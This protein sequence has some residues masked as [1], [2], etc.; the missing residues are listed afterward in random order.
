MATRI[1]TINFLPDIFRTPTNSQFLGATLD[2]IVDQPNTMKIEGYIGSK[3][4][5]GINAKD[6]YVVEPTKTRTDYQLEPGVVFTKKDTSTA[7]DFIS[8][9]GIVDALKLAGGVTNNNDRLFNSEFYS[10]DSFTNLDPLI[11]YTQYYWLKDGAPA[12]TIST[13]TVYNTSAYVVN[14]LPNGYEITSDTDPA[15]SINPTITLLR[16]GIYTFAV[17]QTSQFWIQGAPGVTGYDPSQPNMQTR[18]VLGVENNGAKVGLVTFTVPQK[19]AQD[20]YVNLPGNNLVDVVSDK[21]FNQING[22]LLSEVKNIDGLTSLEGK[23]V[24]FYND[25]VPNEQGYVSKFY[26]ITLYDEDGGNTYIPPGTVADNNNYEGGYYT[27]VSATFYQITYTDGPTPD[28]PML[29]LV[30]YSA[31]PTNEKIT[32]TSGTTYIGRNFYRNAQGTINIVPYLSAILDTLYYQD[33]ISPDQVGVI[34]LVEN[35]NFNVLDIKSILG[36]K[37]YTSPNKVVFTN[38]LKVSFKGNITPA[39]YSTNEYYVE[40]VGTAIKLIPVTELIAPESFTKGVTLPYDSVPYDIGNYDAQLYI[41]VDQDYI[42]IARDSIDKNPWSRSNRWFHI[43]VI[44]ATAKYNN[45][46]EIATKLATQAN[47]AKRPII[48]F[49]PNLRL[50]NTGVIGKAPVDF[51]DVRTTDAFNQVAGQ[52]NYYPDVEVFT[53][54]TAVIAKQIFPTTSTTI[55]IPIDHDTRSF[56]LLGSG[57]FAVGQYIKDSTNLLPNSAQISAISSDAVNMTITVQWEYPSI[58]SSD[59][60]IKASLIANTLSNDNYAIFDGARIVFTKDTNIAVRNKI[61]VARFSTIVNQ[62]SPVITLTEADDGLVLDDEQ[63]VAFKGYY[64]QGKDWHFDG[65]HWYSSQQKTTVNQPPLFDIFDAA[66]ASL[67][68]PTVYSGTSFKGNKLFAYAIGSGPNDVILGFPLKYVTIGGLVGDISFDVSLNVDKFNY[69]RGTESITQKVNTG[70]VYNYSDIATQKRQLGWQTA[71]APSR[72]YQLFS[73]DYNNGLLTKETVINTNPP[74]VTVVDVF[75]IECDIAAEKE[76][77]WPNIQVSRNN[78]LLPTSDYEVIITDTTT[79]IT[80]TNIIDPLIDTVYQVAILSDQISATAFYQIPINLNNNPLNQELTTLN[81]GDIRGQYQSIFY[82]NPNTTG[83]VF[84]PNNYRDLGNLVPWGNKIIQNSASLVLPGTFLRKP[85]HNLI[86]SLQYNSQQYVIFKNLLVDTVNNTEYNSYTSPANIL[87]DA[88]DQITVSKLE[89]GP[90]FWSDMIPSKSPYI[91]NVYR[92]ANSLDISRY[93]LSHVYNFETANYN[94][95]LVYLTRNNITTQLITGIDYTVST[96]DPTLTITTDLISGDLITIKQYNQTYGSYVPNTPTKLGLYPASVPGVILDTHYAQPT[97]FIKGH[98][99][100]YN[101]LYGEYIDGVLTDLRDQV[102]LEF[103]LRV[104]NNLKLSNTIPIRDYDVLPGFFRNSQYSLDEVSSIYDQYFLNWVGQNRIEYKPQF[105]SAT[106]QYTYNYNQSGNKINQEPIP[107]GNWRGIYQYFYDTASP[108]TAPWEMLGFVNQPTWWT[109][110]YGPA[111]YTSDNL[112][113]WSDLAAGINWNNG[114]P[115]VIPQAVRP[116]LLQVLPV[117]SGGNLVSPFVSIVGNYDQRTFNNNWRAGDV[118]PTEFSYRKSSSWPFDLMKILALTKPANFFNLGVDVDNYKYSKEFNQYLV[119]ERSHL[120]ISDVEIYGTGTAKTSYINWIVDY[121]KQVGIDATTNITTLLDNLDVRLVYRLAGFSD[122]TLLR[123][124]VEK[125]TPNSRNASLMIPDES[126]AVLLYDN[127]PFEQIVYSSVVIQKTVNGW[128]VFGNSQSHAYFTINP[129]KIDGRY[130]TITVENLSVQAANNYQL[131]REIII[132]YGTEFYNAQ[133]VSQFIASYGAHLSSQG[134]LFDQIESGLQVSWEQMIAEFLYW[135]Q[136]GWQVGSIVNIN[137]AANLISINQESAIVQPLTLQRQNF[138]LNQNLYPIQSIDLSVVRDGTLF[139]A[140]ALN[141]GDTVAYGQFNMSAIEHGIV[142]NNVTLF[143]D[144][145]YNLI[146]GLR[147]NRVY[148]RG[149]KS[150]EWNGTLDA[151]GFILNQDNIKEWSK[152]TK[153]TT[154]EIVTFKNKYWVALAK[155]QASETF[156]EQYWKRTDYNQIQK[157]LLPNSSTRS[158]ESTLYYDTNYANLEQDA[159]LLSFSL[160]GY[161][162]RDYLAIADLTDITQI[163]V[164]KNL[165]KEKGTAVAVNTFKGAHLIQ[166]DINYDVYENWA[167]K[168]GEFG[169]VLNNNFIDFRLNQSELTGNPSIVGLTTGVYTTGVQQE[170][171]LYTVFNYGRPITDPNVLATLPTD[172]PDKLLPSA[173][174]ANFNDVKTYS[175]FYSGLNNAVVPLS[176]VY[177]GE[178]LWVADFKGTWQVLTPQSIGQ[179][180]NVV[181]NLN[182]TI[183]VQFSAPHNLVKYQPFAIINFNTNIDGY[184]IVTSVIDPTR[185]TVTL[186]LSSTTLNITGT[187]IGVSFTS[188]RVEKPSDIAAFPVNDNEFIKTKVWVDENN[189]GSWA[190]YRKSLNYQYTLGKSEITKANSATFGSAVA[191]TNNLGYLI[192]DASLGEVY[193]YTYNSVFK[194]YDLTQTLFSSIITAGSFVPGNDYRIVSLG[195]TTNTQWNF[196]AGTSGISYVVGSRFTCANAG[197]GTGTAGLLNTTF[198]TTIGYAGSTF[199]ISQPTGATTN[200]RIV[201]VYDLVINALYNKL[202]LTQ[203]IVAP[204]GVTNWGNAITVSGDQQWIYIGGYEQNVV[205]AYRKS[206]IYASVT[207]II[208]GNTYIIKTLGT[209]D[210]NVVAGTT[211]K[212]YLV[213]D[214]FIAASVGTGTGYATNITYQHA[215]TIALATSETGDNF[216]YSLSTNYYGNTLVVGAPGK[217]YNATTDNW[218]YTY[219]FNRLT[220][221]FEFQFDQAP[222]FT[223]AFTPTSI[224]VSVNGTALTSDKYTLVDNVVSISKALT[225]GD[226]IIV[227]GNQF[228]LMQELT[229]QNEPRTGVQFGYSVDTNNYGTEILVGAPFE[230]NASNQEGAVYRYTTSGGAYGYIVGS[231]E[232]YVYA[233]TTVLINGYQVTIPAGNAASTASA[234]NAAK[235]TNVIASSADNILTIRLANV[236]LALINDKLNLQVLQTN[237]LD[238]LGINVYTQTQ[239][240]N[241]PHQQSRTQF[242]TVVKFNELGS[243]VV[244][245]PVAARYAHTTFDMTDDENFDND[246]LFDNNT[247]Q[248]VDRFRNAGA[249][250]MYDYLSVYNENLHNVGKFVYAQSVDAQNK[251]YGAQ[252]YYGTALDFN[253][254]NVVVGTSGFRPGTING[255]VVVYTNSTGAQ[256]WA[257]YRYS[258]PIVDT[259]AIQNVQLYS[260]ITNNTL[261]HLDYI[262]PLQG[263]LLGVVRENLD[264]VS[265]ADP[266]VYN[267]TTANNQ[268]ALVWGERQLGQLWYNTATTRFVNYHQNDSVTYNSKWWGRVFPGSN[269]QV[270]S[271]ITSDQLPVNYGGPGT[272]Y[273]ITSYSIEYTT[274]ANGALVPVYFY[275]VRN[276]NIIFTKTGKTLSDTICES[277]IGL[278]TATGISYMAPI[279]P[280]IFGLYNAGDYINANDSVLHI[281]FATSRNDD[282]SHSAYNLIKSNYATDFLPGLPGVGTAIEPESLYLKMIDSLSGVDRAGGIV[283]DPFLPKPVQSGI[284]T[285]PRQSFF[286]NRFKA[287]QNYLQY[288]NEVLSQFPI[289]ETRQDATFLYDDTVNNILP[290]QYWSYINWWATG[291]NDN[292]KS[293]LQVPLYSDLSTI[294]NPQNGLIVTVTHN[295]A[296]NQEWYRY[297]ADA[298]NPWVR[299]GLQNGTIKFSSS[300]W[301][302]ADARIGFGDSFFDT[303]P[304]D[305]YPSAETRNIIRA[306]N[307]QIYTDELLIFRNKSLI[308]LFQYIQSETVESQNYLP[309]LNKTSFIDVSHTIRELL[310]LRVYRSDNQDFL[311]GYINEAKPYHVVIKDFIFNYSRTDIYDSD[312][313]DFDLPAQ[314]NTNYDEFITPMLVYSGADAVNEFLPSNNIWKS[315]EYTKWYNNY[316]LSLSQVNHYPITTT[317]SYINL[318]DKN[319]YVNNVSGFPVTGTILIGTE[320]I[321]YSGINIEYNILTGLTRG[322]KDTTIQNHNAGEQ[323]YIDLPSVIVL[324]SGRGYAE[325]PKIT[326]YIDTSIYP[327][328]R[329]D[330]ILA[331]IMAADKVIGVQ[332]INPG[333]GYAVLPEIQIEPALIQNFNSTGVDT[334]LNY[335]A[336]TTTGLV[337]GDLV[338]YDVGIITTTVSKTTAQTNKL[339]CTTT[340]GLYKDMSIIF[341]GTTFGGVK[342]NTLYYILSIVD[343]NTFTISNKIGGT[344]VILST[345]SGNMQLTG[346]NKPIGGLTVGAHYYV[347]VLQSTPTPIVALYTNYV[348]AMRDQDRVNLYS[349]GTGTN[350]I[351]A[352]TAIASCTTTSQPVRENTTTLRFDRT[353]YNSSLQTWEPGKFYGSKNT[354]Q[355]SQTKL[356]SS[357]ILLQS[358]NPPISQILAS[359]QGQTFQILDVRNVETY[360]WSSR[361]RT[362]FETTS[363][364]RITVLSSTLN[365]TL[366]FYVDMP[367]KFEGEA[368]GG[369]SAGVIYYVTAI[370]NN[371]AFS[372][373]ETIGGMPITLTTESAPPAGL[374]AI[375]G[376]LTN[377]TVIKLF[378]PGILTATATTK[379]TNIVTVP[380]LPTGLGGTR[381]FYTGLPVYFTKNAGTIV[382]AGSFVIGES[383]TIHSL[384]E[385]GHYTNFIDVGASANAIGVRFIAT[386]AGTGTGTVMLT[387]FG[388]VI[389][390]QEYYVTTVIDEQ[391]FTMSY[392]STPTQTTLYA[393]DSGTNYI[394]IKNGTGF[395]VNDPIIFTNMQIAGTKVTNFGNIQAGIVYYV[396]SIISNTQFKIST[397]FNGP[398]FALTTVAAATNTDCTVTNQNDNVQ[399][400]TAIGEMTIAADLPISPGQINGQ[401]FAFYPT[402]NAYTGVD[403]I[404]ANLLTRITTAAVSSNDGL[405]LDAI[406]GGLSNVYVNMPFRVETA[407]GGLSTSIT[408]YVRS[409]GTLSTTITNTTT[410][411]NQLTCSTTAGFYSGMPIK[412][413]GI[414]FGGIIPNLTYYVLD[415]VNG[416]T[417]TISNEVGGIQVNLSTGS[418]TMQLTGEQYIT[419]KDG[420]GTQVN[421]SDDTAFV[422]LVQYPLSTPTFNVGYT[423]GGYLVQVANAGSGYAETNTITVDGALLGGES[424]KNDLTMT[425]YEI[426]STGE[427][428]TVISTGDPAGINADYYLKVISENEC[429]LYYDSNL[430]IP[431]PGAQFPYHGITQTNVTSVTAVT[432]ELTVTSSANFAINSPVVFTGAVFGGMVL[433]ETYYI[434]SIPSPTTVTISTLPNGAVFDITQD[435]TGNC[436]MATVGDVSLL[437][438]PF[439]ATQSIV[440]YNH[441]VYQCAVSNNDYDFVLS[442]WEKLDSGDRQLNALDRIV[443]YYQPTINMPGLDLTQLVA[444]IVYPNNTYLD[445][446]FAPADEY[447]YD[448]LLQDNTFTQPNDN[449]Y[450]VQGDEFT[451]GYGPEE[452]VPGIVTD[453]LTLVVKTR[454]GTNWE[455]T[456]YQNVGYNSVSR[457]ITPAQPDQRVY[458]FANIVINPIQV[459][460][461]DIDTTTNLSIRLYDYSVDWVNKIITLP[462]ALAA[463]HI[464]RI[465]V[466]EVGNG[467]QLVRS[468]S[469]TDPYFLNETTQFSEIYLDCHYSASITNGSGLVLPGTE[470]KEVEAIETSATDNTILCVSVSAFTL[471]APITFQGAVFGGVALDTTYY[472]KTASAF[473][474]RITISDTLV[475]G[476]AGPTL[477]LTSAT[478][479]MEVITQADNGLVWTDP[480]VVHNGRRLT[481]GEQ[482]FVTQ[483]KSSTNSIVCT[484]TNHFDVNDS[485]TFSATMFGGVIEPNTVY[486]IATIVD[487]NEFT[488]SETFGGPILTLTD[489]FG[490][491]FCITGDYAIAVA[492]D[493]VGVARPGISAKIVFPVIYN[494]ADDYVSFTVFGQTIPEQYGYTLPETQTYSGTGTLQ[495]FPLYNYASG[496]NPNNAI[497]EIDGL[498]LSNMQYI[499]DPQLSTIFFVAAPA[500]DA[501][502]AVTTYNLTERQYFNTQYDIT[503]NI[504]SSIVSISNAITLPLAN[505]PVYSSTSVGNLITCAS[506][507]NFIV[508]QPIQFFGVAFG[509]LLTDGTVYFV[510]TVDSP[511]EFTVSQTQGGSAFNPG[512]ASGIMLGSVGGQPAIRVTTELANEFVT[513][514][515]VV[516]D[517][518][519]GSVQLNNNV[520]YVHVISDTQFDLYSEPYDPAIDAI[521]YPVTECNTYTGDGFTWLDGMFTLTDVVATGT[522]SIDNTIIVPDTTGLIVGTPVLFTEQGKKAGEITLGGLIVGQEYYIRSIPNTTKFKVSDT[523]AG[524]EVT[525]TT[526]AGSMNVTQWEQLNVDRLWV[527]VNGYRVPS[528]AL[529]LNPNNDLSILVQIAATDSVIIT[530]MIPTATPNEL[531]YIQNVNKD[532]VPAVFRANS[533]TRTWLTRELLQKDPTIYMSDVSRVTDTIIQNAVAPVP[534]DNAMYI[535]LHADR[536]TICQVV[537]YNESSGEYLFGCYEVVIVATAPVLKITPTEPISGTIFVSEGNNLVI[538]ITVGKLLFIDGEY[539]SFSEVNYGANSVSKLQRGINGTGAHDIIPVYSEVY[540][541]MTA[542]LLPE[543]EYKV[544]WNPIP[545]IYNAV[546]G[547]PLQIADTAAANFLKGDMP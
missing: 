336:L 515:L 113:L 494:A 397:Q 82:N 168:S 90:F 294:V 339:T 275:W 540:G 120:V 396:Q 36:K 311:S 52:I 317:A 200:D 412:F 389:A 117:D 218:G 76:S 525:L 473:T 252:P 62:T 148:L 292:T 4:G 437:P 74:T 541:L 335:I 234:I 443:G 388:N 343:G 225:T 314:Y 209:T 417:F 239:T 355:L 84:G 233:A 398:V 99:G 386:G 503:G 251:N 441:N 471:N 88:I 434:K 539:I 401:R 244:S 100:S 404:T 316:G 185:V 262:D 459:S 30:P 377:Q 230:V 194:R 106:D 477:T 22:K 184:Y 344:E 340:V 96:T 352:L 83:E 35:N 16:G 320:L 446:A 512:T 533:N 203:T 149:S 532:S 59:P 414:T 102:L 498:R 201:S 514:D 278:P 353:T 19:N 267:S 301:D 24:M 163:N 395:S 159:D 379:T 257:T 125:G 421:L 265:N 238:Q 456:V 130:S 198:G 145:I 210:W 300:L 220:Q 98:D 341:S 188:Q 318:V 329:V 66:G 295:G 164:Y 158:Y 429:E 531:V 202:Q 511:T 50:F 14:G 212:T 13:N 213:G 495:T 546:K 103:E 178:Y 372:V 472:I 86:L 112:I 342:A 449:I 136:S 93:P 9:P 28:N 271:W 286:Y 263:K 95:V 108:D 309:W 521:N 205:Y 167:I 356:A 223:L 487:D 260:A 345:D 250:Y 193:R 64:N 197:T 480:I 254:N 186:S 121:E 285:R 544:T 468:N 70:Y 53:A 276:T 190:V 492:G 304:Y 161:R 499:I 323:I 415:I 277:Y 258:A 493:E 475:G 322:V 407:I 283:P 43:D 187:G 232:C 229:T 211:G 378:Y 360:T 530:N 85:D 357:S 436:V 246:T 55:V 467:D 333:S 207:N 349:K 123:F 196:I 365:P 23:T 466:Y 488:I 358:T 510:L 27:E 92:F 127:Q 141:Q 520:Y 119:K 529:R 438:D 447:P 72:Q 25:G 444:N 522:S 332:V 431:V 199:A 266:A 118:G 10:W 259:A 49:Y 57:S 413:S 272:P 402:S 3:F 476:V 122:K 373:S 181:N 361:I 337:T 41:P 40:G 173:G 110:R 115:V 75:V 405:Y 469:Q 501:K 299:I 281:G 20:D 464:L 319:L 7:Q 513:N 408:Y 80:I 354:G 38:G 385:P 11:N 296:G 183:T 280:N 87:D 376:T 448:T 310:P 384:G 126:Y 138:V 162:P 47:K 306:L 509:N 479:S 116:E 450:T 279:Q 536:N 177:V 328:P 154:G 291:Y 189:D 387:T 411:V 347:N 453:N 67:G 430:Y 97:Y 78:V 32:A 274:N 308:L 542:N 537:L 101:K 15:G 153:Y 17:S 313:T 363:P 105:Y 455:S 543:I 134:V 346:K 442:K 114:D 5:Y 6:Y 394:T 371:L 152:E 224:E 419:V 48:E 2:Q 128:K 400:S 253:S 368:F 132:P 42:T 426:S 169:G 8:Y 222:T 427:I 516:I 380:L 245:A 227:S 69:V 370:Y 166:G 94:G 445:N 366:G 465:D 228:V 334:S 382:Q 327:A 375:T 312:I 144:V 338:R 73:V 46:P 507:N 435:A 33:S 215:S 418:G 54:Q 268:G 60:N 139:T 433:G 289:K 192:S 1:R 219:V 303:Q 142:F 330:A 470:P 56:V 489:A 129:P 454:P 474:D 460:V 214:I 231:K 484:S 157:G 58:I 160:I 315:P 518:T 124:F 175:Y 261:E 452:L 367:I 195:T 374:L 68:N 505:T 381:G 288:A 545:G 399:L 422:A 406:S 151:Q 131:N 91:T 284:L 461:F 51:I 45:N 150:A 290:Q 496:S 486:Y 191:Y 247:T 269:V 392:T 287:L 482:S 176:R 297:V 133:D 29:R 140:Q 155:L 528:S 156:Q 440:V 81:V 31:I 432:N 235:I 111:P 326:A 61:Y 63:T 282:V 147:Q 37:T 504:I 293:S 179:V 240:I 242:G 18:D 534:V 409:T 137:P 428:V 217:N 502:I 324:N 410:S 298:K 264:V 325:P 249:V 104:Y 71:V 305:Y 383:Y 497:V 221:T 359:A 350:N 182:D 393:T 165:I 206:N 255:Q 26:D 425:V 483:T 424:G 526:D 109:S 216:G 351:L 463:N 458:S 89:S 348:D 485:V 481:L 241:D 273:D 490:A 236:K 527:T 500:L 204:Q 143:N 307:E 34:K 524:A 523:R 180:I 390:N 44:N 457:E 256:N 79:T 170:V 208:A 174:Y 135:A 439:Y 420:S 364:D 506:T 416:N 146:T 423:S 39:F 243:F 508:N 451:A 519:K 547:D 77:V 237:I 462:T 535:P 321:G 21:Q 226:I 107:I 403:G 172:T 270:L 478:G 12:V 391:N 171:P 538:T 65:S 491:A 302:Y 362:V 331:P 517:A 248:W 369:L